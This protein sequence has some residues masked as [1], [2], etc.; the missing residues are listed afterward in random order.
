M[1][2]STESMIY[3]YPGVHIYEGMVLHQHLKASAVDAARTYNFTE[4]DVL[5]V[6]YP[7]SG[8]VSKYFNNLIQIRVAI[9]IKVFLTFH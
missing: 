3:K 2:L 1:A 5:I 8:R 9:G 7:K 4:N 6:T